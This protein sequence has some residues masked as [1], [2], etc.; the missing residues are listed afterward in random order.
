[1]NT[2]PDLLSY[3]VTALQ[4]SDLCSAVR[5]LET[6]SFATRKFTFKVRAELGT[7]DTLQMRIYYNS[8]HVDYSYQLLRGAGLVMR[9]DN[10]EHFPEII[11]YPHHFHGSTGQVSMSPLNGDVAHD[12]SI[13]LDMLVA[14]TRN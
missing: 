13:V 6:Q 9:W 11:T 5:V 14:S 7:G 1:M 8:G 12:L 10:K 2:L 3:V 4:R